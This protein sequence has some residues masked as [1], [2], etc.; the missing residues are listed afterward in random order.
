M[1]TE[2]FYRDS[3]AHHGIKGQR[4]GVRRFQNED[5]SLTAAG[6]QRY[7]ADVEGAKARIRDAESK[8]KKA[9]NAYQN[10]PTD[11]NT[12]KW[13]NAHYDLNIAK[14]QLKDEK[15]KS[16]LNKE[17]KKSKR[18]QKLEQKYRDLGMSEEEAAIAAYKR[19]KTEKIVA[20]SVGLT[21][22]AAAAYVAYK[23]YDNKVDK[24][25][26]V[27]KTPLHN[28]SVKSDKGVEDA[29]Y[30]AYKDQDRSTYKGL[31]GDTLRK[32]NGDMTNVFDTKITGKN[33][34]KAKIKMANEKSGSKIM[35]EMYENDPEFRK[36]LENKFKANYEAQ[37]FNL[38]SSPEKDKV[39][40]NAKASLDKGQFNKDVFNA[41][42]ISLVDTKYNSSSKKFNQKYYSELKK[43][44]YDAI[45]DVND[46]HFSGYNTKNP[47]IVF[48]G[49]KLKRESAEK[50]GRLQIDHYRH[51]AEKRIITNEIRKE[52]AKQ[53]ATNTAPYAAVIGIGSAVGTVSGSRSNNKI[54]QEYRKEHPD[55]K[56]SYKEILRNETRRR[57]NEQ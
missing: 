48:N 45:V 7:N 11:E 43:R 42:N 44:G 16:K 41:M 19:A 12:K 21:V 23:H 31:Y 10:S 15:V 2:Y 33:P 51:E 28:I 35:K 53:I 13:A 39:Y 17:T 38:F 36:D 20:A 6:K 52:T 5:G 27:N 32:K 3:L 30:A 56:L 25:I 26:D 37:M 40:K 49:D 9:T 50:L 46:K 55:T 24:F 34:G 14:D 22:A 1:Y 29:F 4:W 18:R 8:Y 57:I 54:V 47:I